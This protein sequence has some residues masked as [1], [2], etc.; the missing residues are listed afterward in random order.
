MTVLGRAAPIG[1]LVAAFAAGGCRHIEVGELGA[2]PDQSA[3]TDAALDPGTPAID[4]ARPEPPLDD[5]TDADPPE[6]DLPDGDAPDLPD[7]DAPDPPDG[8]APD[9]PDSD[10]QPDAEPPPFDLGADPTGCLEACASAAR[11]QQATCMAGADLDA[12]IAA[13]R[14]QGERCREACMGERGPG[15][16]P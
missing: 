11:E 6:T 13:A 7:G 14:D 5:A 16:A 8:D 4:G 10:L 2:L 3:I 12:C 9:L 1:A 15:D